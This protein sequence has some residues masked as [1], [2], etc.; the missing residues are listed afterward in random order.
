MLQVRSLGP[1][2]DADGNYIEPTENWAD[3]CLCRDEANNGKEVKGVD[4]NSFTYS[5]LIQMPK[6]I[7]ALVP[8]TM[9]QV[10]DKDNNVRVKAQVIYSRKDQFHTRAWV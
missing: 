8:G 9:I 10:L 4:G 5:A 3:Y 2:K 6:G 1:E 7:T